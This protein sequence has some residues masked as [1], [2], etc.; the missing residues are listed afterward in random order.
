[1]SVLFADLVGFTPLSESRDPEEVRALLTR[2]FETS[3]RLIELYGGTV[4]KFIGDAVMAVWGTPTATEDDAERAVRAALDLVAEF[5]DGPPAVVIVKHA[6]PC[7]VAVA[8]TLREAYDLAYRT[9]PTS[10]FGGII[11]FNQPL[12]G[13]TA[14]AVLE[15]QFVEVLIVPAADAEAREACARRDNVRLLV[16]GG[17]APSNARVELRSVNGGLLAQTRDITVF[18]TTHTAANHPVVV[19]KQLATIDQISGGRIGLNIVAGWNKPEYEAL[20]LTL[21]DDHETRY[22]YAQEWFDIVRALWS[23]DEAFD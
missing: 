23:R 15:R 21:P 5:R 22:G 3:R 16:T 7:G 4:E 6:N 19:A 14:R 2:Y 20:G 13:P 9:D 10:A 17:L 11:A 8:A 1:M 12:D 18:A